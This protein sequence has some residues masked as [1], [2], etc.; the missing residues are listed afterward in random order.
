MEQELRQLTKL[1]T[2]VTLDKI[3]STPDGRQTAVD[4]VTDIFRMLSL[5]SKGTPEVVPEAGE[6][7]GAAL[8]LQRPKSHARFWQRVVRV[9]SRVWPRPPFWAWIGNPKKKYD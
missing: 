6:W 1:N 3:R 5:R 8:A 2:Q 9:I 4:T 7:L